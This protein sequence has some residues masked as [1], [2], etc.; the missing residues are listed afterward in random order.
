MVPETGGCRFM[1]QQN[2]MRVG[3]GEEKFRVP[4]PKL[5]RLV[6]SLRGWAKTSHILL[7]SPKRVTESDTRIKLPN[8][9]KQGYGSFSTY[10]ATNAKLH[11]KKKEKFIKQSCNAEYLRENR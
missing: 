4:M 3:H 2:D 1:G 5:S 11:E 9:D 10:V 8:K 6:I 7:E